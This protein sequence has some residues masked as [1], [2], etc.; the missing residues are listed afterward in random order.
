MHVRHM[1]SNGYGGA[2]LVAQNNPTM[3]WAHKPGGEGVRDHPVWKYDNNWDGDIS[4]HVHLAPYA[5]LY[6]LLKTDPAFRSKVPLTDAEI[7]GNSGTPY[8][9]RNLIFDWADNWYMV[10]DWNKSREQGGLFEYGRAFVPMRGLLEMYYTTGN[11]KYLLASQ[12]IFAQQTFMLRRQVGSFATYDTGW[13]REPGRVARTIYVK[14]DNYMEPWQLGFAGE[15]LAHL[16]VNAVDPNIRLMIEDFILSVT[17]WVVRSDIPYGDLYKRGD[18]QLR[19]S[20]LQGGSLTVEGTRASVWTNQMDPYTALTLDPS[21]PF[22]PLCILR[23]HCWD[24]GYF[25]P[26]IGSPSYTRRHYPSMGPTTS[27]PTI[28][29]WGDLMLTRY[30][31]TGE[32]SDLLWAFWVYRDAKYFINRGASYSVCTLG[33]PDTIHYGGGNIG[34][35]RGFAWWARGSLWSRYA[36]EILDKWF[37]SSW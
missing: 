28:Y 2:D 8:N 21:V 26:V 5:Y 16:Y 25:E 24:G 10:S 27:I 32:K 30:F 4:R 35:T 3:R 11:P 18:G 9:L 6:R 37:E 20:F 19:L 1:L 12:W 34:K 7:D 31:L 23:A 36:L 14:A 33:K 17:E 15:T 29:N 13:D 22:G